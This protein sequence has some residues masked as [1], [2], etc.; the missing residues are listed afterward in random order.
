MYN[1]PPTDIINGLADVFI[2]SSFDI[3]TVLKT[4]FKSE[5][6]FDDASIGISIKSHI[7]NQIH[8]FRSLDLEPE[9]IIININGSMAHSKTKFLIQSIIQM[10]EIEMPY[11]VSII[12]QPI[13]DK[14]CSIRSTLPAGLDTEPGSMNLL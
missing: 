14:L 3:T 10:Q 6:F 7:D 13:L 1:D 2:A 11:Q 12:K 5:H 9:K 4:L 8:F